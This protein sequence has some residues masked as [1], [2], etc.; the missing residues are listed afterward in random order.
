MCQYRALGRTMDSLRVYLGR[1]TVSTVPFLKLASE[2]KSMPWAEIDPT[3]TLGRRTGRW[4]PCMWSVTAEN[5]E[6][7]V[8][9]IW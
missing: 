1:A 6:V 3:K 8:S 7:L 4:L 9:E 2:T 5:A